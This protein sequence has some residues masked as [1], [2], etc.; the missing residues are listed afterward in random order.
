MRIDISRPVGGFVSTV[1]LRILAVVQKRNKRE[2]RCS[3]AVEMRLPS[4]RL[5]PSSRAVPKGQL[6]SVG[7]CLE[8]RPRDKG[9]LTPL[10]TFSTQFIPHQRKNFFC[11]NLRPRIDQVAGKG[12][13]LMQ[14]EVVVT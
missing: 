7:T 14:L 1:P 5:T 9:L 12:S 4:K 13:S 10:A 2:S 6:R 8:S 3:L 11:S